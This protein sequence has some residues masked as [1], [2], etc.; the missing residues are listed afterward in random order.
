MKNVTV[1]DDRCDEAPVRDAANDQ[2]NDGDALLETG[3]VWRFTC[4][5]VVPEHGAEEEN[6]IVN[7]ATAHATDQAGNP[8]SDQDTHSTKII[9]P[10]I[11]VEKTGAA[12]ATRVTRSRTRSRRRTRA[13]RRCTTCRSAT[14]AA[15]R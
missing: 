15:P 14:T 9:H 5:M 1:E 13:T 7:T 11:T 10:A 6:P 12:S 8:V 2:N 3:E 4:T